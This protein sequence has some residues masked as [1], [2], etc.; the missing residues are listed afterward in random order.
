MFLSLELVLYLRKKESQ[1]SISMK[2]YIKVNKGGQY[3]NKIFMLLLEHLST[4]NI[5]L[6]MQNLSSTLIIKPFNY[7]ELQ[8]WFKKLK[9]FDK[10]LL[11]FHCFHEVDIKFNLKRGKISII[12][13]IS[14]IFC[15]KIFPNF[16]IKIFTI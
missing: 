12:F 3:L 5:I 16:Y 13:N 4:M 9:I 8:T 7:L 11:K 6:S 15:W 2:S 10:I 14:M 1:L